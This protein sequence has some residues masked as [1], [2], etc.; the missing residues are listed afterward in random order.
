MEKRERQTKLQLVATRVRPATDIHGRVLG[1]LRVPSLGAMITAV[2]ATLC[3]SLGCLL[4]QAP[5]V[6]H[7]MKLPAAEREVL[8]EALRR[9]G[10]VDAA[11][12]ALELRTV[13]AAG[14]VTII[15]EL[16]HLAPLPEAVWDDVKSFASECPIEILADVKL[17]LLV[18]QV[19]SGTHGAPWTR[20]VTRSATEGTSRSPYAKSR[21]DYYDSVDLE[22]RNLSL[23][24][25]ASELVVSIELFQTKEACEVAARLW[26]KREDRSDKALAALSRALERHGHKGSARA[27]GN[28][29]LNWLP[30]AILEKWPESTDAIRAYAYLASNGG[31]LARGEAH[32]VLRLRG[33]E[34]SVA[35]PY[36]RE[37]LVDGEPSDARVYEWLVTLAVHCEHASV[38]GTE[39]RALEAGKPSPT[40]R[41]AG[42][43]LR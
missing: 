31:V 17:V 38:C 35:L 30:R 19:L 36:L 37:V 3:V 16:L 13:D 4:G 5:S 28:W 22:M 27:L 42:V 15:D 41:L 10:M 26:L 34:F 39:L 8:L 21:L 24:M 12:L 23:Q 6:R 7:L 20:A 33:N 43:L 18:S 40:Q 29:R 2:V 25:Q 9:N 1:D 14:A 32:S 11:A